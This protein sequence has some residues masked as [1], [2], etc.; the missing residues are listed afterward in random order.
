MSNKSKKSARVVAPQQVEV[1]PE[2]AVVETPVVETPVEAKAKKARYAPTSVLVD[3]AVITV[4]K[5]NPKRVGSKAHARYAQFHRAGQTVAE[6][7]AANKAANM[8]GMLARN[9]LR[10]DL[11]HGHIEIALP[12]MQAAEG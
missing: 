9:D 6:Y 1:A 10:W 11:E 12:E 7:I 5:A 4:V 3:N 2:V 8:S